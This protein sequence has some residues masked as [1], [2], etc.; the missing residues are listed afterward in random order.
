MISVASGF[1]V[2]MHSMLI[3][4]IGAAIETPKPAQSNLIGKPSYKPDTLGDNYGPGAIC[5]RDVHL[6][7]ARVAVERADQ[8]EDDDEILGA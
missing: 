5:V 3:G 6:Y 7:N 4:P 1:F 8:S 2:G